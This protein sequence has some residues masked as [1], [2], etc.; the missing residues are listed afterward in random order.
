MYS[1]L[2]VEYKGSIIY[3]ILGF[4]FKENYL[5]IKLKVYCWNL[6][7]KF[8]QDQNF[9]FNYH[10]I[11]NPSFSFFLNSHNHFLL[12]ILLQL[13]LQNYLILNSLIINLGFN[14]VFSYW[15]VNFIN[16]FQDSQN[17]FYFYFTL[18]YNLLRF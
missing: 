7:I 9:I 1:S 17:F 15:L 4:D 12:M 10:F 16:L 13:N 8:F 5:I 6:S 3:F 2:W 18:N 11:L 14:F